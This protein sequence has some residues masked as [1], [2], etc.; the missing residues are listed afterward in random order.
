MFLVFLVQ[1]RWDGGGLVPRIRPRGEPVPQILPG[2]LQ[3]RP[4]GRQEVSEVNY[5]SMKV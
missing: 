3:D 4:R 5:F 2:L 1:T